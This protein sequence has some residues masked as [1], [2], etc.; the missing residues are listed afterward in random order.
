MLKMNNPSPNTERLTTLLAQEICKFRGLDRGE[1]LNVLND[2]YDLLDLPYRHIKH[3]LELA[4]ATKL[5]E[6][7]LFEQLDILNMEE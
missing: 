5:Y 2:A 3:I 1:W 7:Y 6:K 4:G